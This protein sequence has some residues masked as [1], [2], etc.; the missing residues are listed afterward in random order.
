MLV[1]VGCEAIKQNLSDGYDLIGFISM[2]E[3]E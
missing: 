2:I 1:T 3:L